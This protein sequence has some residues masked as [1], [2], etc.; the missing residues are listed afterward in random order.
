M[1]QMRAYSYREKA[2]HDND[3]IQLLKSSLQDCN[4]SLIALNRYEQEQIFESDLLNI[5]NRMSYLYYKSIEA[6]LRLF[7]AT[8]DEQFLSVALNYSEMEKV[9]VLLRQFQKENAGKQA[10][11]PDSVLQTVINLQK[12]ILN[13]EYAIYNMI[14]Q[15]NSNQV[16]IDSLKQNLLTTINTFYKHEKTVENNFPKYKDLKYRPIASDM[17]FV[18][19]ISQENNVLEYVV[20]DEKIYVFFVKK[21][22][23]SI[24]HFYFDEQFISEVKEYY[25]LISGGRELELSQ[26]SFNRFTYLSNTLYSKLIKPFE[27][28]LEGKSLLIIPDGILSTIP[29]ESLIKHT[30]GIKMLDYSTLPYLVGEYDIFYSY[31]LTLLSKQMKEATIKQKDILA[32][33][34]GYH[35]QSGTDSSVFTI[36]DLRDSLGVL[37]GARKEVSELQKKLKSAVYMDNDATEQV[38]KD[39]AGNYNILHL[40]MH[41]IVNNENPMYSKLVFTPN[42][43]KKEDGMLN[44]YEVAFINIPAEMVVLSAC[45][46]ANGKVN[47]GEGIVGLSRGFLKAGSK[48]LLATLWS[49]SDNTS[50]RLIDKFYKNILQKKTKSAALSD[51]KREYLKENKGIGSHPFFWAGYILIGNNKALDIP[52]KT[53]P[54]CIALGIFLL[55]IPMAWWLKARKCKR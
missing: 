12:E 30:N 54:L 23:V 48:S 43:D 27:S 1:L 31:S 50:Y 39:I 34:P 46:T 7:R 37:K 5:S 20:S 29:F 4:T 18:Q 10:Q 53:H 8:N 40:A 55:L 15:N 17:A 52:R 2:L 6:A 22:K 28:Q 49:V 42:A 33:A 32:V 36:S 47:N 44:T 19:D 14:S 45:N 9:G 3:S 35:L 25:T 26:E 38:F 16:F 51:A 11:V 21:G 24:H 41:T 13:M